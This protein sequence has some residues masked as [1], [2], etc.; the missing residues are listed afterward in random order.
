MEKTQSRD[1]VTIAFDRLGEGPA[2][3]LVGG[4]L[5]RREAGPAGLVAAL[6]AP[7]FTVFTYDRRGRGDS[8]DVTPYAVEREIE[9]LDA[10]INA[11]GGSACV[12]G[13]S[14]GAVLALRAAAHGS[15]V[16]KLALY[17]PPFILDDSR[18]IAHDFSAQI[19]ELLAQGRRGDAIE[20]FMTKGAEAPAELVA[21]MRQQPMWAAMEQLAPTLTYDVTIMGDTQRGKPLSPE[22][23]AQMSAITAPTLVMGGGASPAWLRHAA[24]SAAEGIPGAQFRLLE[25][26]TH[27]VAAEAIAPAL[28]TFFAG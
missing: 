13:S 12:Y 22:W 25:G 9:D 23:I 14:S 17:E 6:L 24:R 18:P 10:V 15:G 20:Y 7:H 27:G 16:T 11:A 3:V 8:G 1:G 4:A 28:E 5:S 19:V 21:M 2:V 26:Q